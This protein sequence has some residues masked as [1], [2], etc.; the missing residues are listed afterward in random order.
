[1]T[2]LL[3]F[4]DLRERKIVETH[5]TLARWIAQEGFPPGFMV[6]PNTR[7]WREADVDAWIASR[8][9]KNTNLRGFAKRVAGFTTLGAAA[10]AVVEQLKNTMADSA[11]RHGDQPGAPKK[12]QPK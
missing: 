3:R 6:G 5:T 1:M 12:E 2:T 9:V 4:A 10:D 11:P 8:P 7:A